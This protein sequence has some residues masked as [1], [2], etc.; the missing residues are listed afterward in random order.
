MAKL[1]NVKILDM[2]NGEPTRV[3]YNG[4]VYEK[5]D[6]EAKAGDL[7]RVI[8]ALYI[9]CVEDGGFYDVFDRHDRL[10]FLDDDGDFRPYKLNRRGFETFRKVSETKASA[11]LAERL[12]EFERRLEALEKLAKAPETKRLTVGDYAKVVAR[13]SLHKARIGDIVKIVKDDKDD[14]PYRCE[15][16]TGKDVGWFKE[17][18]LVPVTDEEV[19]Q[20]KAKS[21]P[22]FEVGDYVVPLPES[23]KK[24]GITNTDMYLAKVTEVSGDNKIV[25]EI[26]AHKDEQEAGW[27]YPVEPKYFRKATEEEITQF[28]AEVERK[29]EEIRWAKIGRK[30][31]EFKKGDL[32]RYKKGMT[33]VIKVSDDS[34]TIAQLD[35]KGKPL[36]VDKTALTLLAPVEQRFDIAAEG[37]RQ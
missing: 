16:L 26:V 15:D 14:Q 24:Y 27:K 25:I 31:G 5:A 29:R 21:V 28:K 11:D 37:A 12:A 17:H 13:E 34:V 33:E 2:V 10:M 6:D 9:T 18:E 22:K 19:T 23:D 4:A 32:V 35:H 36:S 7:V 30:P 8:D 1:E 20:A 3:E